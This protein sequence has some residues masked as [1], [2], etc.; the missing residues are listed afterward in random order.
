[1]WA[2]ARKLLRL[3]S[4]SAPGCRSEADW[5]A[6]RSLIV[7]RDDK[8]YAC[9]HVLAAARP[10]LYACRKDGDLIL[11]CGGDDHDQSTEDWEVVPRGH[12]LELDAELDAIPDLAGNEQARRTAV[13]EPWTRG[14]ISEG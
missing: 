11:A 12:V 4:Q 14:P 7:V 1:M 2:T 5:L 10:V 8:C 3:A 6:R 9:T 13:G